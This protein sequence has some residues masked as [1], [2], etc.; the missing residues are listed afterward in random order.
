[1]ENVGQTIQSEY[2]NSPVIVSL[3][4]SMNAA[5]DPYTN[6]N[7]FYNQVWNINTAVGY[8]LNVWGRIVGVQRVLQLPTVEFLGTTGPLGV[9]GTVMNAGP[10]YSGNALTSNYTLSDDDYRNLILAKALFNISN[11]SISAINNI[12]MFLFGA[13][14]Q[15]WCTDN[16]NMTMNYV[17]DFTPSNV[18][19]AIIEQSGVIPRPCGVAVSNTLLGLFNNAGVLSLIPGTPGYATS[20]AGLPA[21]SVWSNSGAVAVVPGITPNPLAP[22]VYFGSIASSQLLT[23][24]GGNLPLTG[25]TVGSGQL[26]N[27]SGEIAIS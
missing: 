13:S 20:A 25:A 18:Q 14:G 7:N 11:G 5:I 21:G 19:L 3:I 24:G 16:Q 17:F 26:W 9:S 1:M 6:L 22:A 23:L 8:G 27:N 10:F 15:A 2:A 4:N 12:L